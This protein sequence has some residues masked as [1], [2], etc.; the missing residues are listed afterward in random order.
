MNL[1]LNNKKAIVCGGSKGIGLA[2]AQVLAAEGATLVLIARTQAD[3][4]NAVSSLP[5]GKDKHF[6]IA[7]D[8]GDK[9]DLSRV[10]EIISR[11]HPAVDVLVNNTGGP[12]IG[13]FLSTTSEDFLRAFS[14]HLIASDSLVKTVC[15]GMIQRKWGRV[16]NIVSVTAKVPLPRFIV[17]NTIRGA[18]LNWAKTLS[19]ELAASG[20][21][22]NCVLPGYTNTQRMK[23]LFKMTADAEGRGYYEVEKDW[24]RSIPVGRM[25]EPAEIAALVVF[26]ASVQSAFITG[27]SIPVDGGWTPSS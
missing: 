5:G 7:G 24:V 25:G 20:I 3:L 21:T 10:L 27:T 22:V 18:M 13:S 23:N 26:L 6:F 17:S 4:E 14:A 11:Q 15:P 19:L 8:L 12:S 16:I 2:C 1:S 9:V